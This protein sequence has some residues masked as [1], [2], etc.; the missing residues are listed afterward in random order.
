[1]SEIWSKLIAETLGDAAQTLKDK[2]FTIP[3]GEE[4]VSESMYRDLS[5]LEE[6]DKQTRD[7]DRF[8]RDGSNRG[9][10]YQLKNGTSLNVNFGSLNPKTYPITEF[11][12][13]IVDTYSRLNEVEEERIEAGYP[14]SRK[15]VP[16]QSGDKNDLSKSTP[17]QF[18]DHA[19]RLVTDKDYAKGFFDAG[20]I[21]EA[22]LDSLGKYPSTF[23]SRED[24]EELLLGT[25][26]ESPYLTIGGRKQ[27]ELRQ[28]RLYKQAKALG[29]FKLLPVSTKAEEERAVYPFL[30]VKKV[31]EIE[32]QSPTYGEIALDTWYENLEYGSTPEM[33]L[34]WI[35]G[36]DQYQRSFPADPEFNAAED[37]TVYEYI[38]ELNNPQ[39]TDMFL[40]SKSFQEANAIYMGAVDKLTMQLRRQEYEEN[41]T[42][43][44]VIGNPLLFLTDI[45]L[46]LASDP[47][48]T[49]IGAAEGKIVAQ[50]VQSLVKGSAAKKIATRWAIDGAIGGA[51]GALYM[52]LY[53][54]YADPARE[55]LTT[56]DI[57][58]GGLVGA[59]FGAAADLATGTGKE[60]L[61]ARRADRAI[62]LFA[63][64]LR[65]RDEALNQRPAT[66]EV[67][68]GFPFPSKKFIQEIKQDL[69]I[70]DKY[71]TQARETLE[72]VIEG[73][74]NINDLFIS[75]VNDKR[76]ILAAVTDPEIK[77]FIVEAI[78]DGFTEGGREIG[79]NIDS[80]E[81]G[82]AELQRL[83]IFK[84]LLD[85]Q[86]IDYKEFYN[87]KGKFHT[88]QLPRGK[89]VDGR[90]KRDRYDTEAAA[91]QLGITRPALNTI[92]NILNSDSNGN[93]PQNRS[94]ITK[95]GASLGITRDHYNAIRLLQ[96]ST[97]TDKSKALRAAIDQ[98]GLTPIQYR[99]LVATGLIGDTT[100]KGLLEFTN[101]Y[102]ITDGK[103]SVRGQS[104]FLSLDD[105]ESGRSILFSNMDR[106]EARLERELPRRQDRVGD[107]DEVTNLPRDK[108]EEKKKVKKVKQKLTRPELP[109]VVEN[110][111][112]GFQ[113]YRVFDMMLSD[114]TLG[115]R[116]LAILRLL[117]DNPELE[118]GAAVEQ[119][120]NTLDR[121]NE[122]MS[123]DKVPP[124]LGNHLESPALLRETMRRVMADPELRALFDTKLPGLDLDLI[125]AEGFG[126]I[127][128]VE[129]MGLL[130]LDLNYRVFTGELDVP[131]E[132]V[133]KFRK[134]AEE[135][136]LAV[137]AKRLKWQSNSR[138]MRFVLGVSD[139]APFNLSKE[140]L[141]SILVKI[142]RGH[143]FPKNSVESK[144]LRFD[145]IK[146]LNSVDDV[147]LMLSEVYS[148]E[149]EDMFDFTQNRPVRNMTALDSEK[150]ETYFYK[151]RRNDINADRLSLAV[152]T[153]RELLSLYEDV[154]AI[155]RDLTPH[156]KE[157]AY[158]QKILAN[159]EIS[160]EFKKQTYEKLKVAQK[161]IRNILNRKNAR[162]LGIRSVDDLKNLQIEL[163]THLREQNEQFRAFE[164]TDVQKWNKFHAGLP[165]DPEDLPD[166]LN[167]ITGNL[168]RLREKISGIK[169]SIQNEEQAKVSESKESSLINAFERFA[170]DIGTK[171]ADESLS[172]LIDITAEGTE[173]DYDVRG[174]LEDQRR[175]A[176]TGEEGFDIL[177]YFTPKER[178]V[179]KT[180]AEKRAK[181]K[182]ADW[183][184]ETLDGPDNPLL[185]AETEYSPISL[186]DWIQTT[187]DLLEF[188]TGKSLIPDDIDLLDLN[189]ADTMELVTSMV[190]ALSKAEA[191]DIQ[192]NL[193]E[194]LQD[195]NSLHS[196]L[197]DV[198]GINPGTLRYNIYTQY[199]KL[200]SISGNIQAPKALRDI[201]Y[202][203]L[204]G[205]SRVMPLEVMTQTFGHIS[206]RDLNTWLGRT[207]NQTPDFLVGLNRM[208]KKD[209]DALQTRLA[210][211]L[212]QKGVSLADALRENRIQLEM[213]DSRTMTM[214]NKLVLEV[215]DYVNEKKKVG[216]ELTPKDMEKLLGAPG[217]TG[218]PKRLE[219]ILL[220]SHTH[221]A[222][223]GWVELVKKN[224]NLVD[225]VVATDR[226]RFKNIN[227]EIIGLER[228]LKG[229]ED[230]GI[231]SLAKERINSLKAEREL[232]DQR[233]KRYNKEGIEQFDADTKPILKEL[234]DLFEDYE[235]FFDA[236]AKAWLSL[237]LNQKPTEVASFIAANVEELNNKLLDIYNRLGA[238]S[239]EGPTPER[240]AIAKMINQFNLLAGFEEP[241]PQFSVDI[242]KLEILYS[243]PD[244]V[245][246]LSYMRA[247]SKYDSEFIRMVTL[248]PLS[249]KTAEGLVR[250][251]DNLDIVPEDLQ[252]L[253]LYLL[254]ERIP[255]ITKDAD[256]TFLEFSNSVQ[257]RQAFD[258]D[259]EK[260]L[261]F[262]KSEFA[263]LD[264]TFG[265]MLE[266]LTGD[267]EIRKGLEMFFKN[268]TKDFEELSKRLNDAGYGKEKLNAD[269]VLPDDAVERGL[270]VERLKILRR[271]K[272]N[273]NAGFINIGGFFDL[274]A[275]PFVGGW[276]LFKRLLNKGA[277]FRKDFT[278]AAVDRVFN[279]DQP[280]LLSDWARAWGHDVTDPGHGKIRRALNSF[281]SARGRANAN[282][283][284]F[285]RKLGQIIFGSEL[286]VHDN[287]V[288]RSQSADSTH[289][290]VAQGVVKYRARVLA[291]MNQTLDDVR[292]KRKIAAKKLGL[293]EAE[294]DERQKVLNNI[295]EREVLDRIEITMTQLLN[296]NGIFNVERPELERAVRAMITEDYELASAILGMD[297]DSLKGFSST[298]KEAADNIVAGEFE[299]LRM[300][301][302]ADVSLEDTKTMLDYLAD[303]ER[304]KKELRNQLPEDHPLR[305]SLR[306]TFFMNAIDADS[307]RDIEFIFANGE[308]QRIIGDSLSV[309]TTVQGQ[310]F[311]PITAPLVRQALGQVVY[312]KIK[313]EGRAIITNVGTFSRKQM[314]TFLEKHLSLSELQRSFP[315]ITD[316]NQVIEDVL[317]ELFPDKDSKV[318]IN[319]DRQKRHTANT[320]DNLKGSQEYNRLKNNQDI[321]SKLNSEGTRME[322]FTLDDVTRADTLDEL[323]KV[324]KDTIDTRVEQDILSE[325]NDSLAAGKVVDENGKPFKF[326]SITEAFEFFDNQI[327]ELYKDGFISDTKEA[328]KMLAYMKTV[329]TGRTDSSLP[330]NVS[331][332][333]RL[334]QKAAT[335]MKAAGFGVTALAELGMVAVRNFD[336]LLKKA[337]V[338]KRFFDG[339]VEIRNYEKD[340]KDLKKQLKK[341]Y[342][343]N[344]KQ[345]IQKKIIEL[346]KR[347]DAYMDFVYAAGVGTEGA[348]YRNTGSNRKSIIF[349]SENPLFNP[350]RRKA[351]FGAAGLLEKTTQEAE[352]ATERMA[353]AAADGNLAPVLSVIPG[354][355]KLSDAVSEKSPE[356]LNNLYVKG[357]NLTVGPALNAVTSFSQK[358]VFN[359]M[360]GKMLNR[361]IDLDIDPAASPG[362][363]DE[364]AHKIID[365]KIAAQIGLN[366]ED[367][368]SMAKQIKEIIKDNPEYLSTQKGVRH[369]DLGAVMND[370]RFSPQTREK[371][372]SGLYNW[373]GQ[374]IVR[375][376]AGDLP[377]YVSNS[378][379]NII[380][381]F[382]SFGM[383]MYHKSI[384]PVIQR[385]F[386]GG[387][388]MG[389]LANGFGV[390]A[391]MLIMNS[392]LNTMQHI[393]Y[394][395][396]DYKKDLENFGGFGGLVDANLQKMQGK[397]PSKRY[398]VRSNWYKVFYGTLLDF[399]T[400][401]VG[402]PADVAM[403]ISQINDP[404]DWY[405]QQ[406]RGKYGY[407]TDT[408][409]GAAAVRAFTDVAV[410]PAVAA[411]DLAKMGAQKVGLD[412]FGKPSKLSKK[413]F[414]E[415]LNYGQKISGRDKAF[416]MWK[417]VYNL[418]SA[419]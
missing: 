149:A 7:W 182:G 303:L 162:D 251:I 402:L 389:D 277:A 4:A 355:D 105:V 256:R 46:G 21:D 411:G 394:N 292:T 333:V 81:I 25:L 384:A 97:Y 174:L 95:Y 320:R 62:N 364:I 388:N 14:V 312:S 264:G 395:E 92:Y 257:T 297:I 378:F 240:V 283:V 313:S 290:A 376:D 287:G 248:M 301:G 140:S 337:P 138:A 255:Q 20:Y 185:G 129:M 146:G 289:A 367:V 87:H 229:I 403:N 366:P 67:Y 137:Q 272:G 382:K 282:Q 319:L 205:R 350:A 167:L 58:R 354:F 45:G 357:R 194:A 29:E 85:R 232:I 79:E 59:G 139:Q 90:L 279:A 265:V 383:A 36:A 28:K 347:Q 231:R 293:T 123:G 210:E 372:R 267:P 404:T 22:T 310:V 169:R 332:F 48:G 412:I 352:N 373:I 266:N 239:E 70:K 406:Y 178:R 113:A 227:K 418:A 250:F 409:T 66:T 220:P 338:I 306:S 75:N 234:E 39:L 224:L 202:S 186:L 180:E 419:D 131:K 331:R 147:R 242:N 33:L 165:I 285:I 365:R 410:P 206:S 57:L 183:V 399:F 316:R 212:S 353:T 127:R 122:F 161:N 111:G 115:I 42:S 128:S 77:K 387:I 245:D 13:T 379:L 330:S 125:T 114:Y 41:R 49:A 226:Q 260:V 294:F 51:E 314:K 175:R 32:E 76:V 187:N 288:I 197:F 415:L 274:I 35:K 318:S 164:R 291:Q 110:L 377:L 237:S 55:E 94:L 156:I 184:K 61:E 369:I 298:I 339:N 270:N 160:E 302:M 398:K 192:V 280:S 11:A 68:G 401:G 276:E 207:A 163:F 65:M 188:M 216:E 271:R 252:I 96:L 154:N 86:G 145:L 189:E 150:L 98:I 37:E 148:L 19:Y 309:G 116:S 201:Y 259:H 34:N 356:W 17:Y 38:K 228:S 72:A 392:L 335:A 249:L 241:F 225:S 106:L 286:F 322:N 173:V 329:V 107:T 181:R 296:E 104:L 73:D 176:A 381:Q 198:F 132:T 213:A 158:N 269:D 8:V 342:S 375:P 311:K 141:R 84:G 153:K 6:K 308:V 47:I 142:A 348:L 247:P 43:L 118:V 324:S 170:S 362:M 112:P 91:K 16:Y 360:L 172:K 199:A 307:F 346:E 393:V 69:D 103:V 117:R 208:S 345:K 211:Q 119:T 370:P 196:N 134:I 193:R 200:I 235:M 400:G 83:I 177:D 261:N 253:K 417:A 305:K 300:E 74:L 26:T 222:W 40:N 24:F 214:L 334:F 230:E 278:K 295:I 215:E 281:R 82:E 323:E 93:I 9:L 152:Q 341:T 179:F 209:L 10:K 243:Y 405:E 3:Y 80:H 238:V 30:K 344:E 63:D 15:V 236:Q 221:V 336:S 273:P 390:G 263:G 168:T 258:A 135:S 1:M 413:P 262:L 60:L 396:E 5:K 244:A 191:V 321:G 71:R 391:T 166:I 233:I 155:D 52:H 190:D 159:P 133:A 109:E 27:K 88:A 56:E 23:T 12:D 299:R 2:T 31:G 120:K 368:I 408:I 151:L 328:R 89:G 100:V 351:E 397:E 157:V 374:N 414:D 254:E 136:F 327:D 246:P 130:V 223:K 64:G 358:I 416:R 126:T 203:K 385:T 102:K 371:L 195:K 304:V 144:I 54:E 18:V 359:S 218:L 204:T 284:P 315:N 325:I 143:T 380:T 219:D 326:T 78:N 275:K 349:D 101:N 44:P 361:I 340:I 268:E 124:I 171:A 53:S 363:L 343:P 317:N 121:F 386:M 99:N 217:P 108:E 407:L 50:G